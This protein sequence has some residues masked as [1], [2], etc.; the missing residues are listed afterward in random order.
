MLDEKRSAGGNVTSGSAMADCASFAMS[1]LAWPS[2]FLRMARASWMAK[3]VLCTLLAS[4]GLFLTTNAEAQG[5]SIYGQVVNELGKPVPFGKVR[6]CAY[7]G[8]GLPCSPLSSLYSDL[9]LTHSVSNPYTTDQVGNYSFFVT[10][11]AY[12][13]QITV[14]PFVIYSYQITAYSGSFTFRGTYSPTT[15]YNLGDVVIYNAT[16]YTSLTFNNRG[17]TPSSSPSNWGPFASQPGAALLDPTADQIITSNPGTTNINGA[18]NYF[19]TANCLVCVDM[20]GNF[21]GPV[22]AQTDFVNQLLFL[23]GNS[24]GPGSD[25]GFVGTLPSSYQ[26]ETTSKTIYEGGF[27][28]RLGIS[29]G[30]S[31]NFN[32]RAA[33]DSAWKY[34]YGSMDCGWVSASSEGCSMIKMNGTQNTSYPV[35]TV[36]STTGTGDRSPVLS[37]ND[38]SPG[39]YLLLTQSAVDT[40]TIMDNGNP[41]QPG[42]VRFGSTFLYTLQ[43]SSTLTPS[44]VCT[45][46]TDVAQS[47][48]VQTLLTHTVGCTAIQGTV[49]TTNNNGYAWIIS[50]N[51]N[52]EQI[53]ITAVSPLTFQSQKPH[54][55]GSLIIQGGTHGFMS[56]DPDV[57]WRT[58]YFMFGAADSSHY[59]C[60][61]LEAGIFSSCPP[62]LGSQQTIVGSTYHVVDGAEILSVD[63]NGANE[64]LE[65]N[66]V[67]WTAGAAVEN[68]AN[69]AALEQ[70]IFLQTTGNTMS[71]PGSGTAAMSLRLAGN[72][73]SRGN[74]VFE[75]QNFVDTQG[76]TPRYNFNG[77]HMQ[78]P[79]SINLFGPFA[80][81]IVMDMPLGGTGLGGSCIEGN[82]GPYTTG[83]GSVICIRSSTFP[84][85][86]NI[87]SFE[88][89]VGSFGFDTTANHFYFHSA[90]VDVLNAFTA[91]STGQFSVSSGGT[92]K[93]SPL[94]GTGNALACLDASGNLYRGTA[95]TCP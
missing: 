20:T 13:V 27:Y 92:L 37:V 33:G 17:N 18:N 82:A 46:T 4:A 49:N 95:T 41:S 73:V 81:G 43:V 72:N 59:I 11:G 42:S 48:P 12:L 65:T 34:V 50:Q 91:G 88:D 58:S 1:L 63:T 35:G 51:G 54:I 93:I 57:I 15:T 80:N 7:T 5:A 30:E 83:I 16:T 60:G 71:I 45:T 61:L 6:V 64:I 74:M 39:N 62:I 70:D 19:L 69:A 40:G 66:N 24:Y 36:T 84:K 55:V 23:N 9:A 94:A 32:V 75:I 47:F 77:G 22:V 31:A 52:P 90:P 26:P 25:V 29:Q 8:S 14:A 85:N 28:R 53:R 3:M 79:N 89:R 2:V 78:A 68:P 21:F 56:D 67:P 76:G 44:A 38:L 86:V 10:P 87:L